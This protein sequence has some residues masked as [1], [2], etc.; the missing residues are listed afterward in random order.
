VWFHAKCSGVTD[1]EYANLSVNSN[2]NWYCFKCVF[3]FELNDCNGLDVAAGVGQIPNN[4]VFEGTCSLR[5][6]FKIAHVNINRLI[7]KIDRICEL[8][9]Q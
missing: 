7:N 6:V 9:I 3:P 8:I 5:R 4:D 1:G 2:T